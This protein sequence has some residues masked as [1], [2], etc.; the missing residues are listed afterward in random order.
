MRVVSVGLAVCILLM[1]L[2]GGRLMES[3]WAAQA[4]DVKLVLAADVSRSINDAE[5]DLQRRGYAA[6]LTNPRVL[7]AIRAGR[8]GAIT[9]CFLEWAGEG[10]QKTVVDWTLIRDADDAR[11]FAA[12][13][14]AA[15]RSYVGRTAIGSAIDFSMGVLGESALEADRV[16]IDVSGDGTSNQGRSVT[17]ARDAALGAGVVINGLSI[18]NQRAAQEGGYLALHTNPPGGI[19]KYY[20]ENVIGGFG[21]FVLR[22]DDF[23]DFDEAMILKLVTEISSV[24][25]PPASRGPRN[26]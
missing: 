25:A 2:A 6:A 26:G 11:L 1:A 20:R 18:F 10:E 4:L 23:K 5:F 12:A 8:H 19:D 14:L 3:A 17:E 24:P 13:L 9:V 21:S 7:D 15:P 16:V 22:I